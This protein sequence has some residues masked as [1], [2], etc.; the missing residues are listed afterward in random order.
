[1]ARVIDGMQLPDG[2]LLAANGAEVTKGRLVSAP[3][4]EGPGQTFRIIATDWRD[5]DGAHSYRWNGDPA[6]EGVE[7]VDA[8]GGITAEQQAANAAKYAA[9]EKAAYKAAYGPRLAAGTIPEWC[10]ATAMRWMAA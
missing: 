1:M 3:S 8:E 9:L 6:G 5:T 2:S 7:T 10:M 4:V